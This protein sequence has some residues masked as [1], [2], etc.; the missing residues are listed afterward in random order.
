M[1]FIIFSLLRWFRSNLVPDLVSDSNRSGSLMA[2]SLI[3]KQAGQ[4][5]AGVSP[6]PSCAR[7][8]EMSSRKLYRTL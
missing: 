6:S 4:I 1:V 5:E 2:D 7:A 8:T 3:G